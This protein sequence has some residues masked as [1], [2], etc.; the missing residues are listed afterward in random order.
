MNVVQIVIMTSLFRLKQPANSSGI[1]QTI[2][3]LVSLDIIETGPIF[4]SMFRFRETEAYLT[5][6]DEYGLPVSSFAEA[7][8]ESSNFIQLIGMIFFIAVAFVIFVIMR[9]LVRLVT[10]PCKENCLTRPIRRT[11]NLNVIIMRF[12]LEGCIE[13]GLSATISIIMV[14]KNTKSSVANSLVIT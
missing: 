13:I 8:Y 7:G 1:M 9:A 5:E 2:W 6:Y 3:R 12:T 14:S 4:D 10:R 11:I